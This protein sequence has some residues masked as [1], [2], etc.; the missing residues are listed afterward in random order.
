MN[1]AAFQSRVYQHE[2]R[3]MSRVLYGTT[4][5]RFAS[6][7]CPQFVSFIGLL[8]GPFFPP[9]MIIYLGTRFSKL[10]LRFHFENKTFYPRTH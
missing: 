1:Q 10:S 2:R 6:D 3:L 5:C 9:A 8:F 7:W 4:L